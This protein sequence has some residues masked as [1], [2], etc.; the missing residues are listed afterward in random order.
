[1]SSNFQEEID[2]LIGC[3]KDTEDELIS[4][5]DILAKVYHESKAM[6]D[7]TAFVFIGYFEWILGKL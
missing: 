3:L 2:R 7:D 6:N 4:K 5:K 1:M